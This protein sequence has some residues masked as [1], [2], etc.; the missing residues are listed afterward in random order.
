[1]EGAMSGELVT[2]RPK[3]VATPHKDFH[4]RFLELLREIDLAADCV[5]DRETAMWLFDE[6]DGYREAMEQR[7]LRIMRLAEALPPKGN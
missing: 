1:M 4:A 7:T 2:F 5:C 3:L 6:A